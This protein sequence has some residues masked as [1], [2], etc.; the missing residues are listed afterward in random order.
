MK[1]IVV[2]SGKGGAGKTSVTA[3]FA[4]LA[5]GKAV[6]ADCDVDAADLHLILEPKVR[7][8]HVFMSGHTAVIQNHACTRCGRCAAV[9][10]FDAIYRPQSEQR[11]AP[12]AI[13]YAA[14]EGCGVCVRLCPADAID[15]PENQ[16]GE[17]FVSDTR[18]GPMVHAKLGVAAENSGKLVT[19][20]RTEAKKRATENH[21]AYVL[22]DGSPGIGCP[23]I[24]SLTAANMALIVTEPSISGVHDLERIARLTRKLEIPAAVCVNKWDINPDIT[25]RIQSFAQKAGITFAGVIRYDTASTRAQRAKQ[26]IVEFRDDGISDDVRSVWEKTRECHG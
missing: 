14:C 24:A 4:A 5:K 26:A 7:S 2:I 6:I 18:F 11:P 15:F 10:R 13:D 8:R 22:I 12:F 20:V 16:C 23:V 1:E 3:S 19:L 25:G 9:C 21:A 17:W